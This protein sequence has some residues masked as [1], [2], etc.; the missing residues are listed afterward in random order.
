[1]HPA[2]GLFHQ[3]VAAMCMVLH[4]LECARTHVEAASQ[5]LDASGDDTSLRRAANLGFWAQLD[6]ASDDPMSARIHAEAALAILED[7]GRE[8]S[9]S[10]FNAVVILHALANQDGRR[11]D[12]VRLS[13]HI[14]AITQREYGPGHPDV[15]WA[16][17]ALGEALRD[18]G[19]PDEAGASFEAALRIYAES[20]DAPWK[21][22]LR[23]MLAL[24]NLLWQDDRDRERA[25]QLARDVAAEIP[26]GEAGDDVRAALEVWKDSP[27]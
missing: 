13:R 12:A 22:R 17:G 2:A 11:E 23:T 18:I 7:L 26:E 16:H 21:E 5:I 1:M 6:L 25:E 9:P 4:E 24:A 20:P 15:A 14:L 3:N 27:P 8:N 19:R 10:A